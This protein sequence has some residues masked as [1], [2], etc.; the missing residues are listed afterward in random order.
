M[1][2][3]LRSPSTSTR[4]TGAPR[5]R[6]PAGNHGGALP[7]ELG[8]VVC[9]FEKANKLVS[10]LIELDRLHEV[11]ICVVDE[12]HMLADGDRGAVLELLITKLLYVS[13]ATK[14]DVTTCSQRALLSQL[15][16]RTEQAAEAPAA[17]SCGYGTIQIVG[18]SATLS[19]THVLAEWLGA[20]LFVTDFRPVQLSH[21]VKA[22]GAASGPRGRGPNPASLREIAA[23]S[24][25]SSN[26]C[27]VLASRSTK[28]RCRRR[29]A[30]W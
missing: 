22:R 11:G 19:N 15:R 6:Y 14:Q 17:S 3:V 24:I 4:L 5:P 10:Q 16:R 30:R 29:T 26:P 27:G 7:R 25:L 28:R 18:M 20:A 9:T 1:A 8:V 23:L 21:W 2:I 12:L 13:T